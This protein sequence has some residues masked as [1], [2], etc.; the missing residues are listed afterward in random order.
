MRAKLE[1]QLA[2][3]SEEC[4]ALLMDLERANDRLSEIDGQTASITEKVCNLN[5]QY[6]QILGQL[7]L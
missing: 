7:T 5:L 4:K 3:K 2:T 6:L 1:L